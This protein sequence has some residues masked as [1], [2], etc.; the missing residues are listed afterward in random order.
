M[1]RNGRAFDSWVALSCE[2]EAQA[3]PRTAVNTVTE[4]GRYGIDALHRLAL[5][6]MISSLIMMLRNRWQIGLCQV[7]LGQV[8]DSRAVFAPRPHLIKR[9]QAESCQASRA[10]KASVRPFRTRVAKTT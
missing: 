6:Y 5:G 1:S 7:T 2:A 8:L 9:P 3:A 4:A 10:D